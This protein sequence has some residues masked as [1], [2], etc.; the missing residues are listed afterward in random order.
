MLFR[1]ITPRISK[2]RSIVTRKV[3]PKDVRAEY[4]RLYGQRWEAKLTLPAGTKPQEAKVRIGEFTA[5]VETQIAAIRAAQRGEGQS[6]TQRQALA[7]AGEWY[8][9]YVARH[10]ENPGPVEHWRSLWD[11]LI[12]HLEEH[13]PDWVIE[14]GWRDLEWTREPD[15]RAGVRPLIADECKTAQFLASKVVVLNSEAQAAFLDCVLDELIAAILL[16]ERRANKDYSPDTRPSEF[17]KFDGRKISRP[18]GKT[19]P[20]QLFEAWVKARQPAASGVNRWR[21]VFL[22]LEQRFESADEITED[23]A[24]DWSRQLVTTK[25]GA[26]T[27]ND[28]W[29]TAARTIFAWAREERLITSTPFDRVR[30]TEPKRVKQRETDAFMPEEWR[31]IL[32]AASGI[33][34]PRTTFQSAQRWVPWLCAYSGARPGEITQLRG[35]DIQKRDHIN[36]MVLTPDAGTIK[37]GKARTV[38]IHLAREGAVVLRT[39]GAARLIRSD[40]PEAAPVGVGPA[41]AW[42]LGEKARGRRQGAKAK[43]RLASHLQADRRQGGD[44]RTNVGLHHRARA[45]V[46]RCEVWCAHGRAHGGGAGEVSTIRD[47]VKKRGWPF[48]SDATNKDTF[49][50]RL[51]RAIARSNGARP[52]QADRGPRGADRL[53]NRFCWRSVSFRA[54]RSSSFF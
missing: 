41:A 15:V 9:W 17:P 16:L 12:F 14:D 29:L 22:D 44:K 7:L 36:V 31:T 45:Q 21:V 3:I 35:V 6:L 27:V 43:P 47:C 26:R 54:L 32:R 50:E 24:W 52:A 5:T 18:T 30:V 10:E 19:S 28:V 40:E 13:A 11:A 48:N 20:W 4:Q 49:A 38:P 1:M 51:E 33:G 8:S 53:I 34:T 25:R 46:H 37:T 42:R 23:E 39:G 2:S